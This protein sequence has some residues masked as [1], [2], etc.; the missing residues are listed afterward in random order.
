MPTASAAAPST[1]PAA[2]GV[3]PAMVPLAPP[4]PPSAQASDGAATPSA[5]SA[6][7]EPLP[8]RCPKSGVILP[9]W[10]FPNP[11]ARR[12]DILAGIGHSP[13]GSRS[14]PN[15][16]RGDVRGCFARTHPERARPPAVSPRLRASIAPRDAGMTFWQWGNAPARRW[17]R[18]G[19]APCSKSATGRLRLSSRSRWHRLLDRGSRSPGPLKQ[20]GDLQCR[21][22][23][24]PIEIPQ[25]ASRMAALAR[26][27]SP[28]PVALG[29]G[30]H[31]IGHQLRP[32]TA[33]VEEMIDPDRPHD[34]AQGLD[35][36]IL[37][38]IRR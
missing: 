18:S 29:R 30:H 19:R 35:K 5:I 26:C 32:D 12:S 36:R 15:S 28:H 9:R 24:A 2:P 22:G 17:P 25:L 6:M 38:P 3:E 37:G 20:A 13:S 16:H 14:S 21:P 11:K 34:Q 27:F 10:R 33:G 4:R 8:S 7:T 1:P 23:L 31:A